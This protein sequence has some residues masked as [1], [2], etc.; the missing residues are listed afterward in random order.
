MDLKETCEVW[1]VG[2]GHRKWSESRLVKEREREA[3]RG[4][5]G[6]LMGNLIKTA[7]PRIQN[8][9]KRF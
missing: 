2:G 9:F 6:G 3:G 7:K 1:G 8:T 4:R 5:G